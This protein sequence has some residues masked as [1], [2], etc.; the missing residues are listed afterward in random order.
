ML[1]K[2]LLLSA[3]MI[4]C[5][6]FVGQASADGHLGKAVETRQGFMKLVG[7]SS[8]P[9]WGWLKD[10]STYDADTAKKT[11]AALSALAAYPV[12]DLFLEGTSRKDMG[13]KT[14]ATAKIWEDM[15]GFEKALGDWQ[16]AANA[17]VAA[18]DEGKDAFIKAAGAY[19]GTCGGCHEAYRTK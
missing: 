13:E 17:L 15:G 12:G 7:W 8:G 4:V 18:A 16:S 2:I 1:R 19:G 10:N 5:A 6:T 14:R 9:I 11:A 3:T